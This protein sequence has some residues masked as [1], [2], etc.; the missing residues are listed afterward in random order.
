M[1]DQARFSTA[2]EGGRVAGTNEFSASVPPFVGVGDDADH[3]LVER[4]RSFLSTTPRPFLKWAGSKRWLLP[5]LVP[6]LPRVFGTYREPFL[7]SAALF[8]LLKPER[9]V[10]GDTCAELIDTFAAVRDNHAAV[11]RYVHQLKVDSKVFYRI[12]K[13]RSTAPFRRAAEF[14]YLNK[15][16][17]NGLYRVNSSGTFNVP[18]GNPKAPTIVDDENLKACG[19]LLARRDIQL[20][21][22][23]FGT[24]VSGTKK[25]DLIYLDPPYVTGHSNNGFIDYN[26]TLFAW[27]DQ[28]RLATAAA[29]LDRLGAHVFVTNADHPAVLDLY[30]GFERVLVERRSTLASAV[31]A[32]RPVREVILHNMRSG[33]RAGNGS[34]NG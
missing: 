3:E 22:G 33:G 24:I 4:A 17:W 34:R 11:L 15:T 26:E 30:P 23:D 14:I 10:L 1:V 21:T 27:E 9:A 8:F 32:R 20:Q 12:R 7:G 31:S 13:S 16:C 28:Q 2:N 19:E 18:F 25:D 5:H 29:E 6:L